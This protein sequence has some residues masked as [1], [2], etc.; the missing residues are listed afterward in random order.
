MI[1]IAMLLGLSMFTGSRTFAQ[2]NV[3][4]NLA[5]VNGVVQDISEYLGDSGRCF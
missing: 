1:L 4:E 2:E 3:K 5:T